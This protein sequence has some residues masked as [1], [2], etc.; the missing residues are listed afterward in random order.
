M[1]TRIKKIKNVI[2]K[3]PYV[4]YFIIIFLTYLGI[5]ILL[6]KTY[7]TFPTIFKS[8]KILFLIPFILLNL[9][10]AFLVGININLIIVKFKELKLI[11]D[12][13]GTTRGGIVSLGI[14]GGLLG[15][16]CP[17]CFVG[18]FPAFLGLFGITMTLGNLPL[19]GLEIQ[20]ISSIILIISLF[21]LTKE[22]KCKVEI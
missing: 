14:F 5:N 19:H 8:Y 1:K 21:L 16:A 18:L 9:I 2:I 20:I 15:G 13:K 12:I 4:F 7:I 11:N 3:R 17:G 10:T 6:N 22:N